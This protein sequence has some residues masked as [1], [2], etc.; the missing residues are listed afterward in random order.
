MPRFF[1]ISIGIDDFKARLMHNYDVQIRRPEGHILEFQYPESTITLT[2][3]I[4]GPWTK[5]KSAVA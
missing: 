5:K 3:C 1:F 4:V 2:E